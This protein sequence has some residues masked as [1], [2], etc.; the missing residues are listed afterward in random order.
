MQ[1]EQT[2]ER[3]ANDRITRVGSGKPAGTLCAA[4]GSLRRVAASLTSAGRQAGQI[5]SAKTCSSTRIGRAPL[6]PVSARPAHHSRHRP[7]LVRLEDGG[8]ALARFHGW[9][10]R[11]E[12]KCLQTPADPD[13]ITFL[14]SGRSHPV[15]GVVQKKRNSVLSIWGRRAA[16]N[17]P[18]SIVCVRRAR[19]AYFDFRIQGH[20][21]LQLSCSRCEVGIDRRIYGRSCSCNRLLFFSTRGPQQ[22][23][24]QLSA[25]LSIDSEMP[26]TQTCAE[27]PRRASRSSRP[28]SDFASFTLRQISAMNMHGA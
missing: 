12:R 10:F 3:G 19:D 7:R 20:Y 28:S 4:T 1:E 15:G 14:T 8:L 22:G 25:T 23:Y 18:P 24:W 27:F 6:W 16:S 26:M 2:A 13:D 9:R 11:R 17:Y 5:C 21:R